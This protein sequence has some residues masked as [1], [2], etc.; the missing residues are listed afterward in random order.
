[1]KTKIL[2]VCFYFAF[3]WTNFYFNVCVDRIWYSFGKAYLPL[4]LR[5]RHNTNDYCERVNC[6]WTKH[7]FFLYS[8]TSICCLKIVVRICGALH[9]NNKKHQCVFFCWAGCITAQLIA[10]DHRYIF[11]TLVLYF[12]RMRLCICAVATFGL[13]A[14]A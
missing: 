2:F 4:L 14:C 9:N 1:M 12:Y 10:F 6:A 11:S 7:I 8:I 13:A 5:T 3:M